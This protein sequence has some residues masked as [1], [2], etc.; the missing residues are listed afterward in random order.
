ME[1]ETRI[2]MEF[3]SKGGRQSKQRTPIR[4]V[5]G[6]RP[7]FDPSHFCALSRSDEKHFW[8]R[9]RN[10]CIGEAVRTLPG[11]DGFEYAVEIGCGTGIVLREMQGLLSKTCVVGVE[12]HEEGLTYARRRISG[13]L[14]QA[15][16]RHPPFRKSF[17]LV[18]LFDVLEHLEDDIEALRQAHTLLRTGGYV[19][20]T[21]PA[22]PCLWSY[23]DELACHRRRYTTRRLRSILLQAGL[24]PVYVTQFQSVL[25]PLL[26]FKRWVTGKRLAHANANDCQAAAE[27]DLSINP[28]VNGVLDFCLRPEAALVKRRIHNP[29]GTSLLAVA[30]RP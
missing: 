17:D 18:G 4:H 15:D 29:I 12:L 6:E 7:S 13:P 22:R 26:W 3:G 9:S 24:I 10:R 2:R 11:F 28:L 27:S 5:V 16:I 21:V 30:A 19:L 23:F 20:L 1:S 25:L 14:V 8:F